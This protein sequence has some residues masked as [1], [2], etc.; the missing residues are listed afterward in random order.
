MDATWKQPGAEI[1]ETDPAW[2]PTG[3]ADGVLYLLPTESAHVVAGELLVRVDAPGTEMQAMRYL[4]SASE[5]WRLQH[6]GQKGL[7]YCQS[8][9]LAILAERAGGLFRLAAQRRQTIC[10][11]WCA[12]VPGL[13]QLGDP[14]VLLRVQAEEAEEGVWV[15]SL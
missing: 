12:E 2:L 3:R 1:A 10:N 11:R 7:L 13:D 15:L 14:A 9:N 8:L 5:A 6:P 4:R